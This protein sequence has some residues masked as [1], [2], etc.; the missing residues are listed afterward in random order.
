MGSVNEEI[1]RIN[2]AK[3]AIDTAII[4][5]GGPQGE[6][7]D[8]IDTYADR[9]RAIPEAVFKQFTTDQ[10]G[11]DSTYIKWVKQDNGLI[12]AD[13]GGIMGGATTTT[14]GAIGLVPQPLVADRTKFLRGDGT[15]VTPT[16]TDIKVTQTNTTTN[17]DYRVIFSYI[18]N[19]TNYTYPVRKS[20]SLTYNPSTQ[21]LTTTGT[22]AATTLQGNLDGSYVNALTNYAIGTAASDIATTDTLNTALGKLEYKANLGASA[23]SWYKSVTDEDADDV[24]N[25]WGEIVDF[26]DAVKEGT[27]IIDEFVTRKTNQEI[28]GKK[29]FTNYLYLDH[30]DSNGACIFFKNERQKSGGGGWADDIISHID[31]NGN[32]TSRLGVLGNEDKLTY[33]Y[34]GT[35]EYNG[36]NLRISSN[37][38]SFGNNNLY[39]KYLNINTVG[40]SG[41]NFSENYT[42]PY[43]N[44]AL[45]IGPILDGTTALYINRGG[46]QTWNTTSDTPK[47]DQNGTVTIP[48]LKIQGAGGGTYFG[49]DVMPINNLTQSLGGSTRRWRYFNG[50]RIGQSNDSV[51]ITAM[52][53]R[54]SDEA[55]RE[56]YKDGYTYTSGTTPSPEQYFKALCRWAINTYANNTNYTDNVITLIGQ[57][58]PSITGT[59]ILSLYIKESPDSTG[60]PKYCSGEYI[61]IDLYKIY[62]SCSGFQSGTSNS[63]WT[64][65]NFKETFRG[66]SAHN[67]YNDDR[68]CPILFSLDSSNKYAVSY[69]DSEV[70]INP[71][72]NSVTAT[73]FVGALHSP[74]SRYAYEAH[75]LVYLGGHFSKSSTTF[76]AI[77]GSDAT[78]QKASCPSHLY[79]SGDQVNIMSLRLVW[80]DKYWHEI[81]CD[82][83][84]ETMWHRN[85]QAGSAKP[86]KAILDQTNYTNYFKGL[87]ETY[88][89]ADNPTN[90]P[91]NIPA[92]GFYSIH[93]YSS[94]YYWKN[95][96]PENIYGRVLQFGGN[97]FGA[98]QLA[99]T[100]NHQNGYSTTGN[101][102][103]RSGDP[104]RNTSTDNYWEKTT[105]KQ[106][107]FSNDVLKYQEFTTSP[108]ANTLIQSGIYNSKA[109]IT[110]APVT[111]WGAL[112]TIAHPYYAM[113]TYWSDSGYDMYIRR[114]G[115]EDSSKTTGWKRLLHSGDLNTNEVY[116]STNQFCGYT[117]A[118]NT[119][120]RYYCICETTLPVSNNV[121]LSFYVS[122]SHGQSKQKGILQFHVRNNDGQFSLHDWSMPLNIGLDKNDFILTYKAGTNNALIVKLYVKITETWK[123]YECSVLTNSSW[124]ATKNFTKFYSSNNSNSLTSLPSNETKVT[125]AISDCS[126]SAYIL[127]QYKDNNTFYNGYQ[128]WFKW[129]DATTLGLKIGDVNNNATST[130]KFKADLAGAIY[131]SN[132]NGGG[133]F[134]LIFTNTA[135]AGT[136]QYNN[137]Y[138]ASTNTLY[139]NPLNT[140]LTVPKISLAATSGQWK[141]GKNHTSPAINI[142]T[143]LTQSYN[144]ILNVETINGH[145][146]SLGGISDQ[147]GFQGYHSSL[148]DN[149]TTWRTYW[150]V[151]NGVL[152][153]TN[154]IQAAGGFFQTSDATLKIF[155][156]DIKVDFD[157]LKSIPKK[158]F[159]WKSDDMCTLQ[160]GTSAQEVQKLYP[161]LVSSNEGILSVAYDKLSILAL[162]S[163]DELYEMILNLKSEN[164]E[165]RNKINSLNS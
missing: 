129:I 10:I 42:K 64:W 34:L 161:E 56:F 159:Y 36:L 40:A 30:K 92:T 21:I 156:D 126:T 77:L 114:V 99:W 25:K 122:R 68:N 37:S 109:P 119:G 149:G 160:I 96:F 125:T 2:N 78:Y 144:P 110:N 127:T 147:F 135:V 123:S 7:G 50:K 27:D 94:G 132:S 80:T 141:T 49:G 26:I 18:D 89:T 62:F 31:F 59:L 53:P 79:T 151:N 87:V 46:I 54:Y 130:Y 61:S 8:L 9:I 1:T 73:S 6:E 106:L 137:L 162:K 120:T 95:Q 107:A 145:Y 66:T 3:T 43:T 148:T 11:N 32:R 143:K 93:N 81:Y 44:K 69:F 82:P 45:V 58:A 108:N 4:Q 103:W 139:Y 55:I 134:P 35:A 63:V 85:I 131:L 71:Y 153:H 29:T 97:G 136:P 67:A 15:W 113:Q 72:R 48:E 70:T 165:L 51:F 128:A 65:S 118:A 150:N 102:Y 86:W 133:N 111:N 98:G 84:N 12:D 52:F 23:Y 88:L 22:V 38:T 158:Y 24:I 140:L 100:Y 142:S 121:T 163:I 115:V 5:S 33:M 57:A 28:T 112:L 17:K 39:E 116:G 20:A 154:S 47:K 164:E 60:L 83:N 152:I 75:S 138:T 91:N 155:K 104:G 14:D 105:W 19:D 13:Y 16:N 124:G 101:L 74:Y 90:L 157:K 41:D 117:T 76:P 146:I